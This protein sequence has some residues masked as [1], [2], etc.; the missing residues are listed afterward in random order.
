MSFA[1]KAPSTWFAAAI[2]A[3]AMAGCALEGAEP[4]AEP[5]TSSSNQLQTVAPTQAVPLATKR[6]ATPSPAGVVPAEARALPNGTVVPL[7]SYT[8]PSIGGDT[9]DDPRPHPW[10][11][12]PADNAQQGTTQG[13]TSTGAS[14]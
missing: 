11:P 12:Q 5:T 2:L 1:R 3:V 14:K 9:S 6:V 10:D 4:T 8:L 7:E 13:S